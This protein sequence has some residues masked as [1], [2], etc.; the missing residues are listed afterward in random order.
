M[1][2]TGPGGRLRYAVKRRGLGDR[3]STSRVGAVEE[4]PESGQ[5]DTTWFLAGGEMGR[6]W[7]AATSQGNTM[8]QLTTP[9]PLPQHQTQ[10][11]GPGDVLSMPV[12][13]EKS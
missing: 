5:A 13:A 11:G 9:L 3:Q 6:H 2:R 8:E 1:A 7:Q 4:W 12:T 10:L